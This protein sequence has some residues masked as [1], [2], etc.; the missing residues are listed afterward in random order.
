MR[1]RRS[2]DKGA[3]FETYVKKRHVGVWVLVVA[4]VMASKLARLV[5]GKA[6]RSSLNNL[7]PWYLPIVNQM[8]SDTV[9]RLMSFVAI[10]FVGCTFSFPLLFILLSHVPH[11]NEIIDG[12]GQYKTVISNAVVLLVGVLG[13]IV[14][15]IFYLVSKRNEFVLYLAAWMIPSC[16]YS[17]VML[18]V[19]TSVL[20]FMVRALPLLLVV[21]PFVSGAVQSVAGQWGDSE[22]IG[23]RALCSVTWRMRLQTV[24]MLLLIF[25][26]C[27]WAV[28]LFRT[29]KPDYLESNLRV[30]WNIYTT[31]GLGNL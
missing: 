7:R 26:V 6:R 17:I 28:V 10:W 2:A 27:S 21:C 11:I 14:S 4:Y 20:L 9:T 23:E 18:V 3:V 5:H 15:W 22:T 31:H 25:L 8:R 24:Q 16:V 13:A 30:L 29:A 12:L 19:P 1:N